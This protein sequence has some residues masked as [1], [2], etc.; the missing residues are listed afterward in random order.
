MKTF[1]ELDH[2]EAIQAAVEAGI[3][4]ILL[5]LETDSAPFYVIT[6]RYFKEWHSHKPNPPPPQWGRL[7][8]TTFEAAQELVAYLLLNKS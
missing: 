4:T 2:A 3:D 7:D 6:T 1:N 5:S 8:F